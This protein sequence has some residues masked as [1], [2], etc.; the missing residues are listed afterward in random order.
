MY[1]IFYWCPLSEGIS[2]GPEAVSLKGR[3][4][5]FSINEIFPTETIIK[6]NR[7]RNL[8]KLC[9]TPDC[10]QTFNILLETLNDTIS[11]FLVFKA[12]PYFHTDLSLLSKS[13]SIIPS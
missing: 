8:I 13:I 12:L 9:Q 3:N 5:F 4:F 7:T 10:N 2:W 6:M 1:K 11:K